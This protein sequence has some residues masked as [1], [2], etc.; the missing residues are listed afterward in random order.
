MLTPPSPALQALREYFPLFQWISM[1]K[2]SP[3]HPVSWN[4]KIHL[5]LI[6][7]FVLCVPFFQIHVEMTETMFLVGPDINLN[8]IKYK[9]KKCEIFIHTTQTN[10]IILENKR[11]SLSPSGQS[12]GAL[13]PHDQYIMDHWSSILG[14]SMPRG[15]SAGAT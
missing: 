4:K 9:K 12:R 8:L 11:K 6:F 7:I 5:Y 10:T 2:P 1:N 14:Q 13:P 15:P 3:L